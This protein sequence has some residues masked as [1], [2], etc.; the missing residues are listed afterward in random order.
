MDR[1]RSQFSNYRAHVPL[2]EEPNACNPCGALFQAGIGVLEGYAA[3]GDDRNLLLA[4]LSERTKSARRS[5]RRFP[6]L[7]DRGE[8]SKIRACGSSLGNFREGVAGDSNPRLAALAGRRISPPDLPY[9]TGRNVIRAQ[10]NSIGPRGDGYIHAG[11]DENSRSLP[12]ARGL[13]LLLSNHSNGCP[14]ERFQFAHRKV[15]L[16]QL[17]EIHSPAGSFGNLG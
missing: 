16:A 15:L 3:Q 13:R 11:I 7:K 5:S 14:G 4:S 8:N 1:L 17:N 2:L 10:V 12:Q 6:F 9:V